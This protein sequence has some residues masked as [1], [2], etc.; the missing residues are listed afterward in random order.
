MNLIEDADKLIRSEGWSILEK[1]RTPAKALF[2]SGP[3]GVQSVDGLSILNY[4]HGQLQDALDYVEN[5][6][7]AVD[8]GA[9][10]GF[11]TYHLRDFKTVHAFEL[12]EPVRK[13]LEENVAHFN[14]SYAQVHPYGL[15]EQRKFVGMQKKGTFGNHVH[16]DGRDGDI[17]LIPLDE[18]E[19]DACDFIKLD[20]EGYEPFILNGARETI[21]NFK[22]II[23]M[24]NKGLCERWGISKEEQVGILLDHGYGI[25]K[26]YKKDIIMG[27]L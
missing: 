10:Y 26:E 13:C 11:M 23:L 1:D 18:M 14:M 16:P 8:G 3:K 17:E 2:K 15:G 25:L 21:S 4:Q 9:N 22:P 24:E 6:D 27:P 7:C 20:C 12:F 5:F 19:L